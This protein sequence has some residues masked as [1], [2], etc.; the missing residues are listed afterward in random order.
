MKHWLI[1]LL[2]YVLT[3]AFIALS[4]FGLSCIYSNC[5]GSLWEDADEQ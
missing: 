3:L 1:E 5:E 2:I 4:C